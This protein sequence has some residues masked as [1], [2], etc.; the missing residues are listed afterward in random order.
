MIRKI[1]IIDTGIC[2]V[3]SVKNMLNK[4]NL[5]SQICTEPGNFAD[6]NFLI[7][8]GIGAF[9]EGM[10]Q[11]KKMGWDEFLSFSAE[12]GV[13]ILG[14]CLGM[15]LLCQSSVEGIIP[16]LGIIPGNITKFS[17]KN[18]DGTTK[19]V[20]H[21]G[22][23]SVDFKQDGPKWTRALTPEP[24][25]YF[26]HSYFFSDLQSGSAI[27]TT[28]YGDPFASVIQHNSVIGLQFHPEKSHRQGMQILDAIISEYNVKI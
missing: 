11:L 21:M 1:K 24:R 27:G 16:G 17:E 6:D 19:K 7:L 2:N 25:F 8:P 13:P 20:P 28:L 3:K 15:Q 26:V 4:I 9:D 12:N 23:N 10:R 22:W 5:E 18:I 14:I